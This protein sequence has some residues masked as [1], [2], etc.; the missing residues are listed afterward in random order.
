MEISLKRARDLQNAAL[1][2]ARKIK[3]ARSVKVSIYNEKR[4]AGAVDATVQAGIDKVRNQIADI[5]ILTDLA[6]RLKEL[7]GRVN[8]VVGVN[9]AMRT[10]ASIDATTSRL[11]A[12]LKEID[13]KDD[14]LSRY[15]VQTE[16][17]DPDALA[18]RIQVARTR[19]FNKEFS[20]TVEETINVSVVTDSFIEEINES[21]AALERQK[22]AIQDQL[23]ALNVTA[24]V[25]LSEDDVA[26]L[27]KH[28][29]L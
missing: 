18:E 8:E 24:K 22:S 23:A 1:A 16:T 26:L 19:L 4:P 11:T 28:K 29:L 2:A 25:T 9:R 20:G 12:I 21:I 27:Q 13:N 7:Y 14:V 6:Y 15:G 5:S 10:L 17:Y 3:I